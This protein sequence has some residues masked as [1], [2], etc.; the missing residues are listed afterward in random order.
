MPPPTLNGTQPGLVADAVRGLDRELSNARGPRRWLRRLIVIAGIAALVVGF[1]AWRKATKPPPPPRFE[2]KKVEQRD[3]VEQVQSTGTVKPLKEVQVGAQVSGRV[4]D[5]HVDFNSQ[6][7]KGDLL[8]EIDPSL[9]GAQ[10]SQSGAQLRA[11]QAG[12]TRAKASVVAA[13]AALRRVKGLRS[14]NLSNQAEVDQAQGNYDVAEA[15]VAAARAQIGQISAQLSSARTTLAYARIYSPIDGVVINRAID[16]GQTV[17]ASFSAPVLFVIAQDL[18]KMQVL[19]EI[20]EADVG[21]LAE[22]MLGEVVVDAFPGEVFKGSIT[23]LRY[24]P[25]NVAGVITYSAVVD[26]ANPEGKL[27]PGMTATV[28][29]RTKEA[30]KVLAVPNAALRFRPLPKKDKDDKP[31]GPGAEPPKDDAAAAPKLAHGKGRIYQVSGGARGSEQIGDRVLDIGI[32]DGS[33][34]ELRGTQLPAGTEVVVE[35]RDDD[36]KQGFR[37]F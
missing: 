12:L 1:G 34:T 5:V 14:D 20:D 24:S 28:T 11:A 9:L 27:R 18:S 19:A 13:T 16:P 26:V 33:F 6:V 3:V 25:N 30:L 8:A 10:V 17:A 2:V 4:V 36:K 22:G 15:D 31:G 32:T 23:Q 37:L 35:Q 21:K 7:K 29:L